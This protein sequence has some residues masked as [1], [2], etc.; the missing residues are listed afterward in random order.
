[1]YCRDNSYSDGIDRFIVITVATEDNESLD[2]F[3]HSCHHNDIPYKILGLGQKWNGGESKDGVL[4][5][6]G[7]AQKINLLKEEL[8]TY[9][10]LGNHIILFTDSYDVIFNGKPKDIVKK[11]REMQSPVVFSAEKTCWPNEALQSQ[12]PDS[13]N[14]YRFLNSGGFIG[15]GDHI[16]TII[17]RVEVDNDYDDQLYYTERYFESLENEKNIKLDYN[18]NIFQTMNESIGDITIKDGK[19]VNQITKQNPL[20]L[21]GNGG[22]SVKN[23]LHEFYLE[24][25]GENDNNNLGID[26][27]HETKHSDYISIGL[28][29]DEEVNDINQTFDHIRFLTYPKQKTSLTIHYSDRKHEYKIRLFEKKYSQLYN[30]FNLVFNDKGKIKSRKEF[31]VKSYNYTDYVILMESNHIFR[32]N[33]SIQ[34]LL[35]ECEDILTPMIHQEGS[36]WVNFNCEDNRKEKYRSYEERGVWDVDYL[37]GIHVIKNDLIPYCVNSLYKN[38]GTYSD[39]DWDV[40]MC[41]NLKNTGNNLKISNTNYY[42]GII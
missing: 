10:Q 26:L 33:K 41:D 34:I 1:M 27:H 42:G 3:R 6:P 25:F 16:N 18:Q 4:L 20:V 28:F 40:M 38:Y 14:E 32:N 17:N 31:L 12:Y 8:K 9:P 35:S 39:L 29:L 24:L 5:Q 21:H 22:Y 23:K 37:Y 30:K 36:K 2:R 13:P 15:Y 7:G 19:I 11:F